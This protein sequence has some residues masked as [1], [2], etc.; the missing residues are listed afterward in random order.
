MSVV[1]LVLL[2]ALALVG[3]L[4]ALTPLRAPAS[5]ATDDRQGALEEE[6][7]ALLRALAELDAERGED[8]ERERARLR[9]RTARVLAQLDTLEPRPVSARRP[10]AP[11]LVGVGVA[12]L[13]TLAGAFTFVPR[14]QLAALAPDEAKAVTSVVQLPALASRAARSGNEADQLA[15]ARAAFTAGRYD[16][17]A[18]AYSNV[19]RANP[20]Q[21]EALRRVGLILLSQGEKATEAAQ[22][23]Q[24][25]A[26][27]A[28][29]D[30][31]GQ[32]YL[33]FALAR[34]GEDARALQALTR[35]QQLKPQGGEAD[36]LIA[37]LRSRSQ[38]VSA[39][40]RVYAANC[41]SCHGPAGAGGIGPSLRDN[42]LSREAM[43]AII[44]GGKGTMP[45]YPNLPERDLNAL[46]DLIAGWQKGQ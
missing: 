39:G 19:L 34:F 44:R 36:E 13:I 17:A 26:Q 27:L 5:P 3:L 32:L 46:L 40:Q 33:G 24:A 7:E 2:V 37:Q 42:G 12:L 28:P 29:Q 4:L 1:A 30:P 38:P 20:R 22:L 18:G 9:A 8:A 41:A 16:D 14:W 10:L 21:P 35:Y 6:R 23:I 15:L 43:A 25:S 31:E 45:A 11:A